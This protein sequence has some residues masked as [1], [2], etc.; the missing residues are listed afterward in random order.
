M[1]KAK[2]LL[3]YVLP[4]VALISIKGEGIISWFALFFV[5]WQNNDKAKAR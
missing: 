2:Y 4:A 5:F 3:V 1:K